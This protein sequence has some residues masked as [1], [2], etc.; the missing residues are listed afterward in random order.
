MTDF[1]I[2]A[3]HPFVQHRSL[4]AAERE[5]KLLAD[6]TG[7][8]FTVHRIKSQLVNPSTDIIRDLRV[9]LDR[10]AC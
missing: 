8:K 9:R 10:D 5:A 3:D 2:V 4:N 6:K 7:E 1:W